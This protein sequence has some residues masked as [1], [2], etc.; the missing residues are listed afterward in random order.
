MNSSS[1][2]IEDDDKLSMIVIST[3]G[4]F[5]TVLQKFLPMKP[6]PPATSMFFFIF[7]L[8]Y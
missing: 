8:F 4:S 1:P 3:S 5:A 7:Y 6:S 2:P